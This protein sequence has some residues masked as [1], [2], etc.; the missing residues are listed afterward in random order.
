MNKYT[1]VYN[2]MWYDPEFK[3]LGDDGRLFFVYAMSSPHSNMIGYYRLPLGYICADLG[4]TMDKASRMVKTVDHFLAYDEVA[5]VV[6]V[7]KYLKYNPIQNPNQSKAAVEQLLSLP[8]NGLRS[9][10]L[11]CVRAF[12]AKFVNDFETLGEPFWNPSETVTQTL[13]KRYAQSETET[14]NSITET[15][16]DSSSQATQGYPQ[17]SDEYRLSCLLRSL[18]LSNRPTAKVPQN[19]QPWCKQFDLILRVDKRSPPEVEAVI[20]WC[21]RDPFWRS[22]ILSPSKLRKQFDRLALKMTE[23]KAR[24]SGGQALGSAEKDYTAGYG[25]FF[26]AAGKDV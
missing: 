16:Q 6:L 8:M 22:N 25:S 7:F 20:E 11:E 9:R 23:K 3:G 19:L 14:D 4:W 10:F 21:Q 24:E 26:D 15:D 13:P 17:D 12:A 5:E 18:I 1:Q 2:Q